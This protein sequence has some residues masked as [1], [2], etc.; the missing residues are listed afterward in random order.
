LCIQTF[1]K[2]KFD[3]NDKGNK[4]M[5]KEQ[6]LLMQEIVKELKDDK[7]LMNFGD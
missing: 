1:F 2:A 4:N 6:E 7:K 5:P 3:K